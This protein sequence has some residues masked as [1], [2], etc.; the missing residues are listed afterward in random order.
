MVKKI[1]NKLKLALIEILYILKVVLFKEL[2]MR[3]SSVLRALNRFTLL[4]RARK[5]QENG[6]EITS[7]IN[8][9]PKAG[10]PNDYYNPFWRRRWIVPRIFY[11]TA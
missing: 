4:E 6:P 2:S 8:N 1:V 10:T 9:V 3:F 11:S 5:L 7:K